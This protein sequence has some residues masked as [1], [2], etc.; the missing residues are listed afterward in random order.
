M[1]RHSRSEKQMRYGRLREYVAFE[2]MVNQYSRVTHQVVAN[3]P[4]TAKQKFH[5]GLARPGQA[6]PNRN[7]CV[8]VHGRFATT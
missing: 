2:Y 8:E 6:G 1:A 3:L 4:L 7:F 5:F